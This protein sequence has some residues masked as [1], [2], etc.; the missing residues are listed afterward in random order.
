MNI[1]K[2]Q[3]KRRTKIGNLAFS[4]VGIYIVVLT[5]LLLF[6]F[7][8]LGSYAN[9]FIAVFVLSLL[10]LILFREIRL[11]KM[12][13]L[14]IDDNSVTQRKANTLTVKIYFTDIE[15]IFVLEKGAILIKQKNAANN[16]LVPPGIA[17]KEEII[18][19]LGQ[20]MPITKPEKE[21]VHYRTIMLSVSLITA[22]LFLLFIFSKTNLVII[23]AGVILLTIIISAFI[24]IPKSYFFDKKMKQS[25]FLMI[26]PFATIL[27]KLV[28]A[29]QQLLR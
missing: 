23:T 9:V 6:F 11:Q 7:I 20:I 3:Q 17:N 4:K 25:R 19:R 21:F 12:Y 26:L 22:G 24:F 28:I 13:E 5:F 29:I 1:Y 8:D 18:S 16:I 15:Y 14:E 2:L 27:A 10:A